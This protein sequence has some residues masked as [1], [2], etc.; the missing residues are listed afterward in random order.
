MPELHNYVSVF[1]ED[2]IENKNA[3]SLDTQKD[4]MVITFSK[5][6]T[7]TNIPARL[8]RILDV[9]SEKLATP[10]LLNSRMTAISLSSSVPSPGRHFQHSCADSARHKR[11]DILFTANRFISDGMVRDITHIV[12]VDGD[13]YHALS[14]REYY[15]VGKRSVSGRLLPRRH[16]ILMG[17]GLGS[18]GI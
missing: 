15:A 17:P 11:Q 9:L 8:K 14:S 2:F 5:V 13:E 12:Y 18:R 1:N 6:L 4:D 16:Y 10:M 3:F 7:D